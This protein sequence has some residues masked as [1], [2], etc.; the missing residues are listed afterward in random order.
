MN[1]N[2]LQLP[3]STRVRL[4]QFQQRVRVI[5][6]AEG[7]LAGLLGLVLSY[8]TVFV[9]DRFIDTQAILRTVLLVTGSIG[10]AIFFP[11]KCHRWVWGTRRMEQ[12]AILLKHKFPALGDQLLGIVELA[13]SEKDLGSSLRLAQAAI[14]QVDAAVRE[15][16]FADAV[17]HA[18]HKFWAT[19]VAVPAVLS[20]NRSA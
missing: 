5:K 4:V 7:I 8:L 6:I 15:R 19:I 14:Q 1:D 13:H 2:G 12:V 16:S 10:M 18:R 3:E 17:P 9:I 11:L 20:P